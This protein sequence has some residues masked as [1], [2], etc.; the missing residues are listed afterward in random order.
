MWSG[1]T[2]KKKR[3]KKRTAILKTRNSFARLIKWRSD[4]KKMMLFLA[5]LLFTID[6]IPTL[7]FIQAF[8]T[9]YCCFG[10]EGGSILKKPKFFLATR[11]I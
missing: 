10:G 9:F 7:I 3:R 5:A 11:T 6:Y 2:K 1:L 8:M 4:I